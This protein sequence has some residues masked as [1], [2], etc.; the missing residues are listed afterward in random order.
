M[1]SKKAKDLVDRLV[2]S[3]TIALSTI[4]RD[5]AFHADRLQTAN[6]RGEDGL[7]YWGLGPRLNP[8]DL[9]ALYQTGS[10]FLP[11]Q[12]RS[13]L[14][15][16]Y[17]VANIVETPDEKWKHQVFLHRGVTIHP[18]IRH[19]EF[20]SAL[21]LTR[22]DI[23]AAGTRGKKWEPERARKFWELVFKNGGTSLVDDVERRL[24][25]A[26]KTP[27]VAI[28]YA[29][30]DATQAERLN[31]WCQDEDLSTFFITSV[32][33][34]REEEKEPLSKLLD[35]VFS[36]PRVAVFLVPREENSSEWIDLEMNAARA[37]EARLLFVRFDS[38]RKWP[39]V[40]GEKCEYR[41]AGEQDVIRKIKSLLRK[42]GA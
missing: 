18:P 15:R 35:E 26:P 23:E 14:K 37:G 4:A 30:E 29:G 17:A 3:K 20:Q 32:G 19:Q 27:D 28:S 25:T 34:L 24:L 6:V 40:E 42:R 39:D 41:G 33:E 12:D 5:D 38:R 22:W 31:K 11:E 16:I 10:E 21:E 36:K 13:V 7:L 1:I 9:V 2:K 8:G